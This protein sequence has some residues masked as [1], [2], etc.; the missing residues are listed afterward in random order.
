MQLCNACLT[1]E[2]I[3]L[4]ESFVKVTVKNQLLLGLDENGEYR[5]KLIISRSGLSNSEKKYEIGDWF[6]PTAMEKRLDYIPIEIVVDE[7][8]Y[9]GKLPK[10]TGYLGPIANKDVARYQVNA[11]LKEKLAILQDTINSFGWD[12]NSWEE[13]KTINGRDYVATGAGVSN[14]FPG[15]VKVDVLKLTADG[16]AHFK[17]IEQNEKQ[18][19]ALGGR[20]DTEPDTS[21]TATEAAIKSA[22]ENAVLT[23]LAANVEQSYRRLAAYCALYEGQTISPDEIEITLNR[24]FSS[25]KMSPEEAKSIIEQRD[26]ELMSSVTAT[27]LLRAGGY[28]DQDLTLEQE[29]ALIEEDAPPPVVLPSLQ[30]GGAQNNAEV[31]P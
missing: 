3:E 5:Q 6:Y 31:Q 16:D 4:T 2:T 28:G 8:T 25:G 10:Q 21:N 7:R 20:Y 18:T 29:L 1:T 30:T 23:M 22:K 11:D 9:A 15:D 13:F 19:R 27:K 17:Y 14:Q 24:Q 12:T 26:A